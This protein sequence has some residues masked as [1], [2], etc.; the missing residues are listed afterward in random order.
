[1][2]LLDQINSQTARHYIGPLRFEHDGIPTFEECRQLIRDTAFYMSEKAEGSPEYFWFLAEKM[3][4]CDHILYGGYR[5]YVRDR[6]KPKQ[7]GFYHHWDLV[8]VSPTGPVF[9]K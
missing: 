7:Q 2:K 9:V 8:V 6:T 3:L 4:F 1:M 5:I